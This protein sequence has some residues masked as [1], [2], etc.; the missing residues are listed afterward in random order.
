MKRDGVRRGGGE[1]GQ[2]RYQEDSEDANETNSSPHTRAPPTSARSQRSVCVHVRV[3]AHA[4]M[5]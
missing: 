1:G 2:A 4:C 3:R 5:T